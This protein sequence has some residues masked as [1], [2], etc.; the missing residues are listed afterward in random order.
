MPVPELLRAG[1]IPLLEQATETPGA[2]QSLE[3][4]GAPPERRVPG[5]RQGNLLSGGGSTQG[6]PPP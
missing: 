3:R 6:G 5:P 2:F 1:F 4:H